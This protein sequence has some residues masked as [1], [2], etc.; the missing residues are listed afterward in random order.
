M[1]NWG[2][3]LLF[4]AD[5]C[6]EGPRALHS[7]ATTCKK[8]LLLLRMQA[9]L[10]TWLLFPGRV[11]QPRKLQMW[12]VASGV[13][14]RRLLKHCLCFLPWP[15]AASLAPCCIFPGMLGS[16]ESPGYLAAKGKRDEAVAVATKLWG[17][18]GAAQLGES[19][20]TLKG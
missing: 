11:L 8:L 16:P 20:G 4:A 14:Y 9:V 7:T 17:A 10:G 5:H 2:G 1:R 19:A 13:V 18:G 12:I 15:F 6:C 3:I